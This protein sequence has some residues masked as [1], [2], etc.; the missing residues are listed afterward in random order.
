MVGVRLTELGREGIVAH[1]DKDINMIPGM[2]YNWELKRLGKLIRPATI[3]EVT[4][5]EA[6]YNFYYQLLVG[7]ATDNIKGVRGLGPVGASKFLSQYVDEPTRYREILDLFSCK[8]E[9]D[10]NAKV[11]WIWRKINDDVTERW[12]E[13]GMD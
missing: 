9:L 5:E 8:E 2:H 10:L 13:F 6:L 3:Y 12:K 11:L 7:D 1:I 4:E